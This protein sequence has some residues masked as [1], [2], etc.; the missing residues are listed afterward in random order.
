MT[1][2]QQKWQQW[3]SPIFFWNVRFHIMFAIVHIILASLEYTV[4][5]CYTYVVHLPSNYGGDLWMH[6][7]TYY[8]LLILTKQYHIFPVKCELVISD[9]VHRRQQEPHTHASNIHVHVNASL[10]IYA[11]WCISRL[12]STKAH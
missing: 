6:V 9:Y 11:I 7:F 1:S 12:L 3:N 2:Y 10:G 5:S 4:T 8:F